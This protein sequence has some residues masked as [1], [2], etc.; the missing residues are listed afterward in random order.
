MVIL[1]VVIEYKVEQVLVDQGSSTNVLFWTTFQNLGLLEM[2][3]KE[4]SST[5]IGFAREVEIC[6]TIDLQTT[7]GAGPDTKT[8]TIKFTVVNTWCQHSTYGY[9]GNRPRLLL[10]LAIHHFRN[11]TDSP[12]EKK[13]GGEA[14]GD[15]RGNKKATSSLFHQKGVLPDLVCQCSHGLKVQWAM[16]DMHELHRSKQSLCPKDP[17][18]FPKIDQLVDGAFRY[19]LLSFMDAYSRYNQIHMHPLDEAKITFANSGS[20]YYKVMPFGLKNAGARG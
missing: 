1:V 13:T 9:V 6:K 15:K 14:H 3:L 7:F 2:S 18:P 10:P 12:K 16:G 19:G 17:Y 8:I 11:M 5:L 20:Y 4:C